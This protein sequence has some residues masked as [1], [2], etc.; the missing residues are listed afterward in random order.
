MNKEHRG[1]REMER[2]LCKWQPVEALE[3]TTERAEPHC[4]K[5]L[6]T[7][8]LS[9]LVQASLFQEYRVG[10]KVEVVKMGGLPIIL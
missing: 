5:R 10:L 1:K 8:W 6:E 3:R 4:L 7:E 9:L 2:K